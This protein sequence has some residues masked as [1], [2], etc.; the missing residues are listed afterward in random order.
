[1]PYQ[2][3]IPKR[4][5]TS[6]SSVVYQVVNLKDLER[7]FEP[8][9]AVGPETMAEKGLVRKPSSLIKVLGS[10]DIKKPL[11]VKA[12]SFSGSAKTKIEAAGGTVEVR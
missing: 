11:H 7:S 5:F 3:R 9:T 12:D 2:R 8:N 6:L 10:G 1:M 4:G